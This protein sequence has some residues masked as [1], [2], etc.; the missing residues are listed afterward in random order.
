MPDEDKFLAKVCRVVE[1]YDVHVGHE[2]ATG[3]PE[4]SQEVRGSRGKSALAPWARPTC[5]NQLMTLVSR[6]EAMAVAW[7]T[8]HD[9]ERARNRR[10]FGLADALI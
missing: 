5:V 10:L 9:D 1:K 2:I 3:R 8:D 7:S 6:D 4:E